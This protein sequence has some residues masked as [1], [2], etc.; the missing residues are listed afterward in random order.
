MSHNKSNDERFKGAPMTTIKDIAASLGVSSGTVS[1]ALNG[2]S[3]ISESLRK[4][5]LDKAVEMGYVRR[6]AQKASKRKM[7]IFIE[8]MAYS[9]PSE[10][11]YDIV[12]GF[13]QAAAADGWDVDVIDAS[14]EMQNSQKYDSYMMASGYSAAFFLGFAL[15]D[16][17][18]TQFQDTDVP[19]VLLDNSV[20][21]NPHVCSVGTDN[22]EGIDLAD[23]HL[24]HLGHEK[25][26]FLDGSINSEVSNQRMEAY[27]SSMVRHHLPVNPALAVYGYFIADAAHYHVPDILSAGASAIICGNDLIA[28][29][30]IESARDAGLRV[31]EDLSVIGFDDLPSAAEMDPPLTTIHQ[32]RSSLGR[33]GFYSAHALLNN[34]SQSKS[35]LRPVLIVRGSTAK[36]VPRLVTN[37]TIDKDSVMYLNP[38][39]YMQFN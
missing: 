15:E 36:A 26:A 27:L 6:G 23:E 18:M 21:A 35:L 30:V 9:D 8:N 24:I 20:P 19:T 2:A 22:I 37:P 5:I 3:D 39:L 16:P 28:Q 11:G 7:A 13:R 31:P 33:N 1:K 14:I 12:L 25:I 17:W 38:E 34:V 10:F 4:T 32:D 29:G